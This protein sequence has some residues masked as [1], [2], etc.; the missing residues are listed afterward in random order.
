MKH[1][2]NPM[3]VEAAVQDTL[4]SLGNGGLG[5]GEVLLVLSECLGR[6]IVHSCETPVQ[7]MSMANVAVDHLRKTISVGAQS[8]G[9]R[10]PEEMQ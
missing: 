1:N 4:R 6:M 3:K 7:M 2:V 8:K 5:T 9:F 10:A